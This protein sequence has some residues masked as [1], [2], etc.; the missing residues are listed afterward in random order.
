MISAL[1]GRRPGPLDE[2]A[3]REDGRSLAAMQYSATLG[4][5]AKDAAGAHSKEWL[6]IEDSNL[7]YLIQSQAAYH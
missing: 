6:G 4:R 5:A 3:T 1:R 7:G 2:C